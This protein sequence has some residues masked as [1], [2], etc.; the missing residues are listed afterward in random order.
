VGLNPFGTRPGPS[1]TTRGHSHSE[2]ERRGPCCSS[3]TPIRSSFV[4]LQV[5][6]RRASRAEGLRSS[7]PSPMACAVTRPS[8]CGR[9]RD[10]WRRACRSPETNRSYGSRSP[11][12]T[13]NALCRGGFRRPPDP[14]VLS[15]GET[16]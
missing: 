15:I 5:D 12:S 8:V 4:G 2:R 3:A 13:V 10:C 6:P 16:G 1:P 14:S 11:T 9:V 7:T